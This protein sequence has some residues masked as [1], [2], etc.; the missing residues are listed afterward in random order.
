MKDKH[1]Q[2][3]ILKNEEEKELRELVNEEYQMSIKESKQM[4]RHTL[5]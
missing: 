2:Y 4:D 3:S 5:A 1:T